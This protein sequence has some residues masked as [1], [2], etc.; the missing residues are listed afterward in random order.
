VGAATQDELAYFAARIPGR[1]MAP[2]TVADYAPH[3]ALA[4]A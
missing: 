3:A 1:P 4:A 2:S